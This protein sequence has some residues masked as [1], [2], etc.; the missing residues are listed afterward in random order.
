MFKP[1]ADSFEFSNAT[2]LTPSD[3]YKRYQNDEHAEFIYQACVEYIDDENAQDFVF[4]VEEMTDCEEGYNPT[5]DE[6]YEWANEYIELYDF[7]HDEYD[8][9]DEDMFRGE[10]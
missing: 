7:D 4:I 8:V 6:A 1:N 2:I 9:Y 10:R 3:C 5:D